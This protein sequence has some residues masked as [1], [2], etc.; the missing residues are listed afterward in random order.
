MMLKQR[1]EKVLGRFRAIV[2]EDNKAEL[3]PYIDDTSENLLDYFLS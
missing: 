3:D 1:V 2:G